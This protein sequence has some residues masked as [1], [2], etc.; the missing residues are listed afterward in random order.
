MR[1]QAPLTVVFACCRGRH[2]ALDIAR[3][4]HYLHSL[5]ITHFDLESGELH[6]A[7]QICPIGS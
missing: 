4:L 5:K 3:G 1:A 2:V 7:S 6:K